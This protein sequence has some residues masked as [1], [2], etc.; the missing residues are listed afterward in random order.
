MNPITVS[1]IVTADRAKVWEYWIKPEHITKWNHAS[2]DWVCPRAESDLREG[3]TFSARMEAADGSEGFDFTGTYTEVVPQERIRY[4][5]DDGRTVTVM[6]EDGAS[7][8]RVTET[9]DPESENTEEMQRSGWQAI[10]D[11]FKAYVERAS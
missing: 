4:V 2:E 5:M 11:N 7:G 1:T 6:F 3:G 8:T 9:F 10:L